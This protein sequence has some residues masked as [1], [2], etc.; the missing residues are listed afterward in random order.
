[1]NSALHSFHDIFD[2]DFSDGGEAIHLQKIIIPMIQRDYAQGRRDPD[3]ERVRSRFLDSLYGA[4]VG[5]PI[6]LDFVYG[7]IDENGIM[8]PLDGQQRL[9]TLFLL[10]WYAARKAAVPQDECAFLQR[11]GY[12]TRYSARFFC[13]ELTAFVPSFRSRLSEEIIDQSWF[14]LE[15]QKDPTISSMLVM[16][17]AIDDKFRNIEG[18]WEKLKGNAITFYFLPIKDM[19]LTDELY[20]KMNSRGKPLTRFEHFKAE[21][22]RC[23]HVLGEETENNI[24]R[25][26][27]RDWTDLLWQYRDAGGGTRDDVITDD[28]FLRYFRFICDIICYQNGESPQGKSPDEFDMLLEYFSGDPAKLRKNVSLMASYFNCWRHIEGFNSPS[29]FL[30]SCMSYSSEPGKILVD[31]KNKLDIFGDCL[32]SYADKSGRTRLFPLNRIVLL[33]AI[34]CYLRNRPVIPDTA[35]PSRLRTVNNLIQNS[36]DEISDRSDRNRL[37]A[38]L[39][40]TEAIM[41]HGEPDENIRNSFNE[42]QL[43][44]EKEKRAF[45][46]KY[47][48]QEQYV[49]ALEDHPNLYGQIGI[50][51]LDHVFFADRFASLFSCDLDLIDCALMTVGDYGQ[52]ERN[53]WRYQYGSARQ[54][55]AWDELFHRSANYSGFENTRDI[56]IGLLSK[57][58]TFTNAGLKE[59]IDAFLSSCEIAHQFPWR[60]YYVKYNVFRP[61]S[62]GKYSNSNKSEKPYMFSVMQTR[63]QWST[64]TYMPFLRA[65]ESKEF[66]LDKDSAGQ[67]LVSGDIHIICENG[68]FVIRSNGSDEVLDTIPIQQNAEGLD[69]EDRIL[70]LRAVIRQMRQEQGSACH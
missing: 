6:T 36:A 5:E 25:K 20:I 45:L 21:L 41:L 50:I 1:M 19:G 55:F 15:W 37:P 34:I 64:N 47:P 8:T 39:A 28:E 16:L 40:Q 13:K 4:V 66:H 46:L 52:Q 31:K 35:F 17:D 30:A 60:Y 48:E 24:M 23:I 65:S 44:E 18:L 59:M 12:E 62:F 56:L 3:V 29:E 2:T 53:K 63:S 69:T 68:A 42:N 58:E 38:I 33:Y 11:F 10:Y 27:D 51:G 70:K 32:H 9:T 22:Q 43:A 57:A 14:P 26:I 54:K 61:G 7:D 67:R 49:L